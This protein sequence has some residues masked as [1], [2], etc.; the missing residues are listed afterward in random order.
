LDEKERKKI[1]YGIQRSQ[2]IHERLIENTFSRIGD[3]MPKNSDKYSIIDDIS[4]MIVTE[5]YNLR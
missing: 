5:I 4:P 3:L 2:P 1:R